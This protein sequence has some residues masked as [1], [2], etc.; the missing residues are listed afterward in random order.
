MH[1]AVGGDDPTGGGA[2]KQDSGWILIQLQRDKRGNKRAM[3]RREQM[4]YWF[5]LK[6]L[7]FSI[8]GESLGRDVSLII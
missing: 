3:F 5:I 8:H 4:S 6:Q 7:S 1:G 2:G